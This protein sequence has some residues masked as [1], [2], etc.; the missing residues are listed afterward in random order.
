[1]ILSVT[2][3]SL[4]GTGKITYRLSYYKLCNGPISNNLSVSTK[5]T[6]NHKEE[7]Y[8]QTNYTV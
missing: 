7:M 6:Q 5:S 2:G 4:Y 8:T 3:S 1:M